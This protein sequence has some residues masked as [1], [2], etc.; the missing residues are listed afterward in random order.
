MKT[1]VEE[2][3][4]FSSF[5]KQLLEFNNVHKTQPY[6]DEESNKLLLIVKLTASLLI[7]IRVCFGTGLVITK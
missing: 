4:Q 6:D 3:I 1:K 2:I 5:T 7:F